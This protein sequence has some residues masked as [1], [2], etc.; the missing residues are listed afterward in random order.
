MKKKKHSKKR[1]HRSHKFLINSKIRLV[2]ISVIVLVSAVIG[3][4][5]TFATPEAADILPPDRIAPLTPGVPKISVSGISKY[6]TS[7]ITTQRAPSTPPFDKFQFGWYSSA[8]QELTRLARYHSYG[9]NMIVAQNGGF[10]AAGT[11]DYIMKYLDELQKQNMKTMLGIP[12]TWLR[13]QSLGTQAQYTAFVNRYKGH[14][15][16]AGWY[17]ADEPEQKPTY[18]SPSRVQTVYNWVKAADPTRPIT[19]TYY[20]NNCGTVSGMGYGGL[21]GDIVMFDVYPVWEAPEFKYMWYWAQMVD[22]CNAFLSTKAGPNYQGFMP[23]VQAFSWAGYFKDNSLNEPTYKEERYMSFRAAIKQQTVGMSWWIDYKPSARLMNDVNRLTAEIAGVADTARN[24][25]EGAG[26]IGITNGRLR[27]K[28][29][30][31]NH[32]LIVVSD[33]DTSQTATVVLPAGFPYQKVNLMYDRYNSSTG[34]Y[35]TRSIATGTDSM[36]GRKKFVDTWN[37]YEV[38]IYQLTIDIALSGNIYCINN[39]TGAKDRWPLAQVV[40]VKNGVTTKIADSDVYGNWKTTRNFADLVGG[41]I[42]PVEINYP[43]ASIP[44]T[45]SGVANSITCADSNVEGVTFNS[46]YSSMTESARCKRALPFTVN[47]NLGKCA[48]IP[49]STNTPAPSAPTPTGFQSVKVDFYNQS[50]Q[51]LTVVPNG[52]GPDY[53]GVMGGACWG[54][55]HTAGTATVE[56]REVGI[57]PIQ[58]YISDP[59]AGI[60]GYC[61]FFFKSPPGYEIK[62]VTPVPVAGFNRTDNLKD[63]NYYNAIGSGLGWNPVKWTD[64]PRQ[65]KV[66][67]GPPSNTQSPTTPPTPVP[68]SGGG[69]VTNTPVPPAVNACNGSCQSDAQCASGL[70]CYAGFCRKPACPSS[71]TCGC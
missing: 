40:V 31:K 23:I 45:Y 52:N 11:G 57:H 71:T 24:G 14:A 5:M 66:V 59:V 16:L 26:E 21:I 12:N 7:A 51:P 34:Q 29:S 50:L 54:G 10:P 48:I 70:S 33:A 58:S 36:T 15:A 53:T 38:H 62:G 37:P 8:G 4:K 28:Y 47:F 64:S 32:Q 49:R 35:E 1:V 63:V 42:K 3:Y 46:T 25:I 67:L 65:L 19:L 20:E 68:T 56:G 13:D 17:I 18:A 69:R 6:S 44:D 9:Q 27:Y 39:V 43:Y 60:D 2:V 55:S 41:T 61:G 30:A 22:N